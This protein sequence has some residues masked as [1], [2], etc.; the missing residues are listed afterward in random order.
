MLLDIIRAINK[1]IGNPIIKINN[2]KFLIQYKT[3]QNYNKIISCQR[4]NNIIKKVIEKN[5]N[6]NKFNFNENNLLLPDEK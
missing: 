2:Y 5:N 3:H 6:L 4:L 1:N